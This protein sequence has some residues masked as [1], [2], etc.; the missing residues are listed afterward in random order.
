MCPDWDLNPQTFSYRMTLQPA[1]PTGQCGLL[2]WRAVFVCFLGSKGQLHIV[3]ILFHFTK[4]KQVGKYFAQGRRVV[5]QEPASLTNRSCT[6][7]SQVGPSEPSTRWELG[8]TGTQRFWFKINLNVFLEGVP[9]WRAGCSKRM[10]TVPSTQNSSFL[11]HYL[12][13]TAL[14]SIRTSSTTHNCHFVFVITEKT[15]KIHSHS[16]FPLRTLCPWPVS[17]HPLPTPLP[18]RATTFLSFSASSLVFYLW[19]CCFTSSSR[20]LHSKVHLILTLF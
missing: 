11:Y 16:N 8:Y 6:L 13:I 10:V 4:L 17:P 15:S 1:E 18:W 14:F 12:L 19:R 20:T 7:Y 2:F 3:S 5:A 9:Y